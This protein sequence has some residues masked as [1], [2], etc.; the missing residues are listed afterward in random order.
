MIDT[1]LK[2]IDQLAKGKS[3]IEAVPSER[4][5]NCLAKNLSFISEYYPIGDSDVVIICLPTP[6]NKNY[7]PDLSYIE[8]AMENI[9][10]FTRSGQLLVLESTS[11]PGTTEEL[12]VE[13]ISKKNYRV[14]H[15]YFVGY[16]PERED[17]GNKKFTTFD[18]PKIV[19]GHTKV[20]SVYRLL[21]ISN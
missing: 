13:K 12:I 17:P 6:L 8:K 7:Q 9:M 4:L 11:Y 18:I 2:R 15:D 21:S 3:D 1:D 10:L 5:N 16:S 20:A 19:S 14:G